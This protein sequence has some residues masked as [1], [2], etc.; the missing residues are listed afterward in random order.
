MKVGIP[1]GLLYYRYGRLWNSFLRALGAEVVVHF[2]QRSVFTTH[3]RNISYR[4]FLEKLE[5]FVHLAAHLSK[6]L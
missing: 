4:K 2:T 1:G 5:I 3:L 6:L